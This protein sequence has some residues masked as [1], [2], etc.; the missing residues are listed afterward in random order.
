MAVVSVSDSVCLVCACVLQN[1]HLILA[2]A[3]GIEMKEGI[4]EIP[5]YSI[6]LLS[7]KSN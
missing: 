7:R 6:R 4:S 1:P 3:G 2:R 5:P